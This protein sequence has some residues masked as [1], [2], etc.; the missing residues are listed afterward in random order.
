MGIDA[1]LEPEVDHICVE[2]HEFVQYLHSNCDDGSNCIS[3]TC[4]V[5]ANPYDAESNMPMCTCCT[6]VGIHFSQRSVQRM[7]DNTL[8]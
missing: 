7:T 3:Q 1:A 8:I 5:N 6:L 4:P 2:A